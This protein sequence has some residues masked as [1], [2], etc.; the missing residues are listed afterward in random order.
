MS[1]LWSVKGHWRSFSPKPSAMHHLADRC[2]RFWRLAFLI[3]TN[4]VDSTHPRSLARDN[5]LYLCLLSKANTFSQRDPPWWNWNFKK[6]VSTFPCNQLHPV[7]KYV[8]CKNKKGSKKSQR[9]GI[10]KKKG[11]KEVV[12]NYGMK[13]QRWKVTMKKKK[14]IKAVEYSGIKEITRYIENFGSWKKKEF[15]SEK[16]QF[17]FDIKFRR[18]YLIVF[19]ILMKNFRYITVNSACTDM[20]NTTINVGGHQGTRELFT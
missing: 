7:E 20:T 17:L 4:S 16:H 15:C 19:E 18:R 5:L 9:E 3:L 1:I 8:N 11:D 12:L 6:N 13:F 14:W 2:E 10:L